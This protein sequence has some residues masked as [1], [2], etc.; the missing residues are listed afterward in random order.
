MRQSFTS[1]ISRSI[2]CDFAWKTSSLKLN[3]K[4]EIFRLDQ[5]NAQRQTARPAYDLHRSQNLQIL[6][7]FYDHLGFADNASDL[8]KMVE[9]R[10][11]YKDANIQLVQLKHCEKPGINKNTQCPI[12]PPEWCIAK[13]Q[14]EKE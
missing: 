8:L 4:E 12:V 14:H 5:E 3:L 13:K 7:I 9:L 10:T 2:K 1:V 11:G 6:D